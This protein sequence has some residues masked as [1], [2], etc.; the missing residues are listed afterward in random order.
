MDNIVVECWVTFRSIFDHVAFDV[1]QKRIDT[2]K[3]TDELD[4]I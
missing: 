1:K 2:N 3:Q 4:V